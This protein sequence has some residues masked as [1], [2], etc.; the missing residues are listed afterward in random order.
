MQNFIQVFESRPR[1][2]VRVPGPRPQPPGQLE[3]PGLPVQLRPRSRR[4]VALKRA[5]LSLSTAGGGQEL[6]VSVVVDTAEGVVAGGGA[7]Q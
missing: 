2:R 6:R 3:R 5:S 7:C 4:T 1:G